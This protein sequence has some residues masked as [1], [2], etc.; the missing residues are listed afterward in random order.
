MAGQGQPAPAPPV[1]VPSGDRWEADRAAMLQLPPVDPV[2]GWRSST[3]LSRD[4]YVRLDA[5]DYSVHPSAIGRRVEV[6]ADL[7]RV[8]ITAAGGGGSGPSTLLGSTSGHQRIPTMLQLGPSCAVHSA[9]CRCP[10]PIPRWP[11]ARSP[12][13][14]A[15]TAV[16][17]SPEMRFP[18]DIIKQV[19]HQMS[20]LFLW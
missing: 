16:C 13:G 15:H 12:N 4:H 9:W 8:T 14:F 19:E 3:R 20:R 2:I 6:R 11:N 5:N 17:R 1:A 10:R 18:W 7:K